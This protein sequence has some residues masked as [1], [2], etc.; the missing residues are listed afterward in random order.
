MTEIH[1][2]AA[3]GALARRSGGEQ[4]AELRASLLEI[5]GSVAGDLDPEEAAAVLW[6]VSP[7]SFA[8]GSSGHRAAR[9]EFAKALYP[10]RSPSLAVRRLR[11][12]MRRA[13][14]RATVD[15]LRGEETLYALAQRDR[16]RA[17]IWALAESKPP[18]DAE[19]KD[20][21]AH[22][23]V[24]LAAYDRLIKLDALDRRYDEAPVV[25]EKKTDGRKKALDLL[26]RV[27]QHFQRGEET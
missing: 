24:R 10:E 2:D 25:A 23:K 1:A 3:I 14:V 9:L 21:V 27:A 15:A 6:C 11:S 4:A 7:Q 17:D 13:A 26:G 19:P 22:M 20:I 5:W 12:V 8:L 18:A 16:I